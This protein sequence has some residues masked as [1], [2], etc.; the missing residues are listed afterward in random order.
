[1][2]LVD[3]SGWIEYFTGGPRG[4]RFSSPISQNDHL[5]VP[6]VVIYEVYRHLTKKIGSKEALFF[7]TQMGKGQVA[8]LDQGLALL[9]AEV[10]LQ[11]RLGTVDALIYATALSHRAILMTL[12]NDFRGLPECLVVE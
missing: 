1:M 8:G 11:Y 2:K 3:S 12:D 6:T 4:G 10:S 5:V 9:A 7:A